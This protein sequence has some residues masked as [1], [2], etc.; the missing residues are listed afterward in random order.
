MPEE[1]FDE[2]MKEAGRLIASDPP[3]AIELLERFREHKD[4]F[5]WGAHLLMVRYL[6]GGRRAEALPVAIAIGERLPDFFQAWW[7]QLIVTRG[8]PAYREVCQRVIDH[9][10]KP[11]FALTNQLVVPFM[12]AVLTVRPPNA[13]R[14]TERFVT[15]RLLSL[16]EAFA[17]A[18]TVDFLWAVNESYGYLDSEANIRS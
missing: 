13:G 11:D 6:D 3:A 16:I 4:F 15:E 5:P 10:Q 7:P 17:V 18:R 8:T 14:L 9:I 1:N 2:V 12:E